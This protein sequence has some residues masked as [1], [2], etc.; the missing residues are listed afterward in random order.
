MEMIRKLILLMFLLVFAGQ[1]AFTQET[2]VAPERPTTAQEAVAT[3]TTVTQPTPVPF[4]ELRS[5]FER[6]MEWMEQAYIRECTEN[7]GVD[8]IAMN[9][10]RS[11][12]TYMRVLLTH[13]YTAQSCIQITLEMIQNNPAMARPEIDRVRDR[14]APITEPYAECINSAGAP[15]VHMQRSMPE[16]FRILLRD[17]HLERTARESETE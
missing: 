14:Q 9:L 16:S 5:E 13:G 12:A 15:L 8:E 4:A 3:E 6:L 1:T 7:V 17:L 11:W 2:P 10:C